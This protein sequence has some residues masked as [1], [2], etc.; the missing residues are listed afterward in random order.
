MVVIV[1]VEDELELVVW[2]IS[3]VLDG[4]FYV[5]IEYG[6]DGV[7]FEGLIYWGY[8]I[9]F[10]VLMVFM[11]ESVF[12]MDFGFGDYF[13][14]KESVMFCVLVIVFLD[15]YYNFVDCGD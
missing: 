8:G 9:S 15:W 1:V 14:F 7:Y 3:R 6:L 13:V 12:G 11:F 5:L 4:M 10:F 2:I